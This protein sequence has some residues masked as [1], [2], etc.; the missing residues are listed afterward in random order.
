MIVVAA[1]PF[2]LLGFALER[3]IAPRVAAK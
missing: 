3:I 1:I 2:V